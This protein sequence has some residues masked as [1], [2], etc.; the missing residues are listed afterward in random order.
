[1]IDIIP[2]IIPTSAAHLLETAQMLRF[3]PRV[4]IDVVDG[5][6]ASPASWPYNQGDID[7]TA[8]ATVCEQ[9]EVQVDIMALNPVA[10]ITAWAAAGAKEV[11]VH[12]ETVATLD[13]VIGVC[14]T[15]NIRLWL[16]GYDTVPVTEYIKH[17]ADIYGVQLMGIHTIGRQGQP[18]SD[19]VLDTITQLRAAAPTLPILI[20]GSVNEDTIEALHRAGA[21]AFVVGSAISKAADPRQA[22]Q[23]LC[24]KVN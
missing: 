17:Q 13:E 24:Q 21:S 12:L 16:S 15:H 7:I 20:D 1:M 14:A 18:L 10:A 4:Q 8:A 3:A 23:S 19:R 2:A 22:Y 9:F 6:F 5:V 11:V